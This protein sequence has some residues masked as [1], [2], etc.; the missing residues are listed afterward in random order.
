VASLARWDS[1]GLGFYHDELGYYSKLAFAFFRS[2]GIFPAHPGVQLALHHPPLYYALI[3]WS[4]K[5]FG[6]GIPVFRAAGFLSAAGL[7]SGAYALARALEVER[8]A[9]A[10]AA[11]ALLC[12][13]VTLSQTGLGQPDLP[14]AALITWSLVALL[15][16]RT[17]GACV[18][19]T[20][21]VAVNATCLALAPAIALLVARDRRGLGR[22]AAFFVPATLVLAGWYLVYGSI[23][24]SMPFSARSLE[25]V[26]LDAGMFQG[27]I[28]VLKRFAHRAFQLFVLDGR[29]L[30]TAAIAWAAF[31]R[32]RARR[33]FSR[34]E[35]AFAFAIGLETVFLSLVGFLHQ[36][37]FLVALPFFFVLGAL[38]LAELPALAAR[39]TLACLCAI[40]VAVWFTPP[41]RFSGAEY[42]SAYR[43][44]VRLMDR[45]G[46]QLADARI[47]SILATWPLT[48]ALG[49]EASVF[50][51]PRLPVTDLWTLN[52]TER[53]SL[54]GRATFARVYEE[55]QRE[56]IP[57]FPESCRRETEGRFTAEICP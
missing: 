11:A 41:D 21:A 20:A 46:R 14:M 28:A 3:G 42:R 18:L 22:A 8:L 27:G 57:G 6:W 10:L 45:V 40:G 51:R 1:L 2:D 30:L 9:A 5:A 12:A 34:I 55:G 7:V 54:R 25:T 16:G 4:A 35:L 17:A 15:R 31:A 26:Q 37:Y 49:A 38:A 47:R 56:T 24:R 19:F 48:D 13:P 50:P 44:Q 39:A 32:L 36:R 29:L 43:D 33:A 53:A 23:E 52:E